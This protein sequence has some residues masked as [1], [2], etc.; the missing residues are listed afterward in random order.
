M[1]VKIFADGTVIAEDAAAGATWLSTSFRDLEA[2]ELYDDADPNVPVGRLSGYLEYWHSRTAISLSDG[3]TLGAAERIQGRLADGR[4]DTI[5][6]NGRTRE[7]YVADS[8]VG[9]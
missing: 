7:V 2:V 9:K 6:W 3:P 1:W 5:E 8:A 4:W